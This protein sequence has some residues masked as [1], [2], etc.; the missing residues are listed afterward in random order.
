MLFH[1]ADHLDFYLHT[2]P[3]CVLLPWH[4]FRCIS[5]KANPITLVLVVAA[6]CLGRFVALFQSNSGDFRILSSIIILLVVFLPSDLALM[7]PEE[8]SRVKGEQKDANATA[9]II[10][11]GAVII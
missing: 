2:V 7:M 4:K 6:C 1:Q 8:E 5:P 10:L 3:K 9:R 11:R